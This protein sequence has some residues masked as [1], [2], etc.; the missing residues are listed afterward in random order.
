MSDFV[1]IGPAGAPGSVSRVHVNGLAGRIHAPVTLAVEPKPDRDDRVELSD[2]AVLLEELRRLPDI[3]RDRVEAARQAIARG[4][5]PTD[6]QVD[7][8]L[9]R[10]L[11]D[12][13]E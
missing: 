8:A 13:A 12:L 1:P 2:R 4:E 5:Y 7:A 10:L 6:A 3:R 11:D 9:E